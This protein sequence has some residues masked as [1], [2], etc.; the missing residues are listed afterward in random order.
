M[1]CRRL[2][3]QFFTLWQKVSHS[4]RR[5]VV[6]H[7]STPRFKQRMV[8]TP[9]PYWRIM[10]HHTSID[11]CGETSPFTAWCHLCCSAAE[12]L[13]DLSHAFW[14]ALIKRGRAL[15]LADREI[16]P[17]FNNLQFDRSHIQDFIVFLLRQLSFVWGNPS[18]FI[19]TYPRLVSRSFNIFRCH[20]PETLNS[21]TLQSIPVASATTLSA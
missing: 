12:R 19:S 18:A 13:L 2:I 10:I 4:R 20:Y 14:D 16:S 6:D 21:F 1:K 9:I 11:P 8:R 5:F 7:T 3:L 15:W 17:N